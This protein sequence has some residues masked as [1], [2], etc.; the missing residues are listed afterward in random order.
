MMISMRR[1]VLFGLNRGLLGILCE[2]ADCVL[3][4]F[5]WCMCLFSSL[6]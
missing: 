3:R 6:V 5:D 4:F 2:V 1:S